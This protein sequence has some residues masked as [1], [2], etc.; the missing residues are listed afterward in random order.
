M[1]LIRSVIE[2]VLES[3]YGLSFG[4]AKRRKTMLISTVQESLGNDSWLNKHSAAKM[5][6]ISIHTL[7]AYRKKYWHVGIH[8]QYLSSRAIR[9]HKGLLL[10]WYANRSYPQAHQRAIETYLA[11]LLSNQ[12][13]KR[14]RKYR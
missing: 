11:S 6:G 13:R 9:Y 4:D 5:L 2:L 14:D 7:K 10:D 8:F 1:N 3:L 12:I